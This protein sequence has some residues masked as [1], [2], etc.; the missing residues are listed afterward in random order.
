[1]PNLDFHG[2]VPFSEVERFFNAARI[3]VNTSESEGFPNTFLQAWSRG[4]PTVSFVDCG[5]RDEQG[6]V[7]VIVDTPQA[8]RTTIERLMTD[9]QER[10]SRG[11]ASLRYF[12]TAHSPVSV[13][14]QYEKLIHELLHPQ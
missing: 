8:L 14:P 11:D 9:E 1:V 12:K 2:F 7:G 6:S 4:I 3:V 5:A 10:V 13:L